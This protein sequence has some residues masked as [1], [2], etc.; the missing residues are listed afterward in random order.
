M[1]LREQE[2]LEALKAAENGVYEAINRR[3]N[4]SLVWHDIRAAID[5]AEANQLAP[6]PEIQPITTKLAEVK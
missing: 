2:L 4:L 3:A 1:T 5:K 6:L